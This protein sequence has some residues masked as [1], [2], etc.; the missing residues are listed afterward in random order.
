MSEVKSDEEQLDEREV[1]ARDF[2]ELAHL[3]RSG[4]IESVAYSATVQGSTLFNVY[5]GSFFGAVIL[6]LHLSHL[7][8][9]ITESCFSDPK[10]AEA[11][12]HMEFN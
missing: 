3:I 10:K 11:Q 7:S 4:E 1:M 12:T 6:A 8:R 9:E 5:T 2:E